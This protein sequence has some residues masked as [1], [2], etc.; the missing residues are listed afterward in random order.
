VKPLIFVAIAACSISASAATPEVAVN[1]ISGG[2]SFY[3]QVVNTPSTPLPITITNHLAGPLVLTAVSTSADYLY[4]SNCVAGGTGTIAAGGSCQI[5]VSFNPQAVGPRPGT[6]SVSDS[7]AATPLVVPLQGVGIAGT[8]GETIT[9]TPYSPCVLPSSSQQFSSIVTGETD[10]SV[11]WYV[12]D[13]P[14]GS[15]SSGTIT[16]SGLYTAPAKAGKH[17]I[18]A[19]S[20]VSSGVSGYV[21]TTITSTPGFTIYPYVSWIAP[22]G[23]QTFQGQLCSVPDTNPVTFTVDGI[24]G[25]NAA[26]GIVSANGV[27]TPP[28]IPGRHVVRA[29]DTTLGSGSGAVVNV[30]AGVT[31]DFDSR[32]GAQY[33]IAPNLF[34]AGRGDAMHNVSDR[35]L[36]SRAGVVSTRLYAQ[37]PLVYA[38]QTHDW[39][40]IDPTIAQAEAGGQK[41][42]LQMA[43]TPPWL[44]APCGQYSQPTDVNQWAQIAASY[45]AHMDATFPGVISD[46]EIGNEPDGGGICGVA[47]HLNAYMALYAG[48]APAMKAQAAADGTTIRVGGPALAAF[49]PLWLT[50]LLNSPATAPYIDFVSYH[51][52]IF[53]SND[54]QVQW[55]TYNGKMS[56]YQGTQTPGAGAGGIYSKVYALVAAGKTP[57]GAQTPIY[58]TEF[59]TNWAFYKDC[60]RNDPTYAPVWN[61]LYVSDVL[62][63]VYAGAAPPGKLVYF[64][65]VAYPYFCM[66]GVPDANDDCLYSEGATPSPYPSFYPYQLYGS[67]L[68]L[69]G[70]GHMAK[71]VTPTAGD[72]GLVATAFYTSTGDSIVITN[73]TPIAYTLPVSFQ[74]PGIGRPLATLYQIYNGAAINS[75]MM[76][77]TP[78]GASYTTT[79]NVPAY[80]VQ[81]VALTGVF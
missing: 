34:G 35:Q 22:G 48:A 21:T 12:D 25:G 59:N 23:Q 78:Q 44:Q 46:Y 74:N 8:P 13:Q 55:D 75:F 77:L 16:T 80:S 71:S 7:A 9:V 68:G 26:V 66:I 49:D 1:P 43:L 64:A 11:V 20:A 61:S 38:T 37:I 52:Y 10:N 51:Q 2:V 15:A 6:L 4:T 62:D 47:N 40:Q 29:T 72:G 3:H 19:I 5:E 36:L 39:T 45:V 28:A 24:P 79:V 73:P 50:T 32:S 69:T 57:L 53:G 18:K 56:L 65:A 58:V 63:A 54:L 30:I 17:G 42:I 33:P 70:G 60:C 31:A 67:L 41:V 76:A 27:Y 14:G 81:A